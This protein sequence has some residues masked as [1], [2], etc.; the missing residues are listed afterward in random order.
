MRRGT[1]ILAIFVV[2]VVVVIGVSQF[3]QSQPPLTITV[4]VTPLAQGWASAMIDTLNA[5][6]PLTSTA[7][8]IEYVLYSAQVDD[9]VIWADRAR[10]WTTDNHP[11]VWIALSTASVSYAREARLPLTV[12]ASTLAQT[13][14][15]WGGFNAYVA[16]L[17][18][19]GAA[20]FDWARVSQTAAGV[21]WSAVDE[22]LNGNVRLAFDAPS[23]AAGALTLVSAAA[24]Y[25]NTSTPTPADF[26][27]DNF[28]AWLRPMLESVNFTTLG[29]LPA[30][31]LAARGAPE[32]Q[33]GL[34]PESQWLTNLTGHLVGS[35]PI[36]FSYPAYNVVFDFPLVRW[37]DPD[38][39][40]EANA[41]IETLEDWLSSDLSRVALGEYG[42]RHPDGTGFGT[43]FTRARDYGITT[44][45]IPGELVTLPA[46]ADLLSYQTW[47]LETVG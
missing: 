16:A 36:I 15:V 6:T 45:R 11:D 31:A 35:D 9:S 7:Q 42:L 4:A 33:I 27:A 5:S 41:A 17:T 26:S 37:D 2:G 24:S 29:T 44:G 3:L 46:R 22:T 34:L 39:T 47:L 19:D 40:D 14:P 25:R 12:I 13:E 43:V 10:P 21:R 8:R 32:A 18:A 38:L 28:R 30:Q 20:A 23:R 1:I